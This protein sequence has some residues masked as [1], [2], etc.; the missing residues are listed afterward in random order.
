EQ[1]DL[2]N[3]IGVGEFLSAKAAES[4]REQC[5][6]RAMRSIPGANTGSS[7]TE[8]ETEPCARRSSRSPGTTPPQD[9][10]EAGRRARR[11]LRKRK[12]PSTRSTSNASAAKPSAPPAGSRPGRAATTS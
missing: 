8:D 7:G 11:T 4:R 2:L 6:L 10:T 5:R 3:A 1:L 9:V 12:T